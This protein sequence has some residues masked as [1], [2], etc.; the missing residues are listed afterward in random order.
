MGRRVW[1]MRE[2][3]A[4]RQRLSTVLR[5]ISHATGG[6]LAVLS[7]SRDR[8]Y[9]SPCG[10]H[11]IRPS[12]MIATDGQ[13]VEDRAEPYERSRTNEPNSIKDNAY[14]ELN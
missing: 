2:L 10:A 9:I 4:P 1:C 12:K 6:I 5:G 3:R 8:D 14:Q 11:L 13:V 7:R